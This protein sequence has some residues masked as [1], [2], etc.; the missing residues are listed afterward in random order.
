MNIFLI[1]IGGLLLFFCGLMYIATHM[2]IKDQKHWDEFYAQVQERN[3]PAPEETIYQIVCRMNFWF[4]LGAIV[5][6]IILVGGIL[7]Q[8]FTK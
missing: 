2:A 3:L 5:G 1:I 8:V 4:S 7:L 6:L